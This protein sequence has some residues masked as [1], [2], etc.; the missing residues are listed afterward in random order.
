MGWYISSTTFL[1]VT[2][3]AFPSACRLGT[4]AA[5]CKHVRKISVLVMELTAV[6]TELIGGCHWLLYIQKVAAVVCALCS[7]VAAALA[8]T[9]D[10]TAVVSDLNKQML[11]A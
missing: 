10:L 2:E 3:C 1:H 4:P 7:T 8:C 6:W 5:V 11:H 9:A